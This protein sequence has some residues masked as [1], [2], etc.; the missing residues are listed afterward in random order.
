MTDWTQI[1]VAAITTA[2]GVVSAVFAS[3]SRSHAT[4]AARSADRAVE[5]SLRPPPSS[6]VTPVDGSA[7]LRRAR[8][9]GGAE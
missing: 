7:R 4:L 5:A 6:E 9:L 8:D 3:R 2:G 1:T